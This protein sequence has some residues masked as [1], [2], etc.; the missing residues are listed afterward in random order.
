[1]RLILIA[2]IILINLGCSPKKKDTQIKKVVDYAELKE[3]CR[4]HSDKLLVVNFWATW[5]KPCVEELPHF[6]EVNNEFSDNPKYKMILVSLDR[7]SELN[8]GM[9]E[10]AK[11]LNLNTDL[12]LLND[13]TRMNEWIPDIDST[14]SGAI[15]ATIV[16]KD[17]VKIAFT[18]GQLTK[19]ELTTLI[20]NNI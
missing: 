4:S 15:P 7:A 20:S 6:M 10:T 17:G 9:T 2:S 16:F 5:C 13:N 11:K 3:V 1:M 14:W 8:T 19:E 12:Y 18:E